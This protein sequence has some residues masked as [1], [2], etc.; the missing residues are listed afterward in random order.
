MSTGTRKRYMAFS[1]QVNH[2]AVS[3]LIELSTQSKSDDL[4]SES[5]S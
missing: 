2:K 3:T 1:R 5:F 4:R